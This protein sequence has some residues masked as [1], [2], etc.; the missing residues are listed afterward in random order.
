MIRNSK[1]FEDALKCTFLS[2]YLRGKDFSFY[3]QVGKCT[4]KLKV[5]TPEKYQKKEKTRHCF[6]RSYER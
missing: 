1:D 2:L 5:F 4:Y 3:F 6:L